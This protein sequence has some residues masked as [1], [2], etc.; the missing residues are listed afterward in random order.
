MAGTAQ[1]ESADRGRPADRPAS[2]IRILETAVGCFARM[3]YEGA[4]MKEIASAAGVSKSLLHYHFESKEDLLINAVGHLSEKTAHEIQERARQSEGS[5]VERLLAIADDLY[6]LL[7]SDS[8][9]TAFLTEMYAT[10]IHNQ[11][12]RK[13]LERYREAELELIRES[14]DTAIGAYQ[15]RFSMSIDRLANLVQSLMIGVAAQSSVI[16]D[17]DE[18][19][20]R[21]D[22][23]K[24]F[25]VT[26]LM[27]PLLG[28]SFESP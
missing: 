18:L 3:G 16:P 19:K 6:N 11:R 10:A 13:Q 27:A 5:P 28:Q 24:Q 25:I 9:K 21:W 4:S 17:P 14:L 7:L 15:D 12:V 2:V 8:E 20:D 26:S 23:I 1:N 22:D